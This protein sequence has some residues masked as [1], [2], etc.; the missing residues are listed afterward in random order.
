MKWVK[1]PVEISAEQFFVYGRWPEGVEYI[2]DKPSIRT[3]EGVM[4][5]KDGSWVI[6][7]VKG[8][9]YACKED[10]FYETYQPSYE[11]V[12]KDAQIKRLCD[13]LS[14][15]STRNVVRNQDYQDVQALLLEISPD[16]VSSTRVPDPSAGGGSTSAS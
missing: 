5:V 15:L 7:G 6:T 10:I 14:Y 4:E 16:H 12:D 11:V 1:K 2:N 13:M 9:K 8:E 3:L